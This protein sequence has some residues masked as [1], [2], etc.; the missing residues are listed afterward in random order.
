[1]DPLSEKLQKSFIDFL[2][3]DYKPTFSDVPFRLRNPICPEL[4]LPYD[5]EEVQERFRQGKVLDVVFE[6]QI[7]PETD[8]TPGT[9]PHRIPVGIDPDSGA[10]LY[11]N[12]YY[13]DELLPEA[14]EIVYIQVEHA[15]TNHRNV[16][17]S[18]PSGTPGNY[19]LE[20]NIPLIESP[21]KIRESLSD[22]S[23][24][25]SHEVSADAV[26]NE[27]VSEVVRR[28]GL[29]LQ[30]KPCSP[31]SPDYSEKVSRLGDRVQ[32]L[33][34]RIAVG[35][36]KV[37]GGVALVSTNLQKSW[38]KVAPKAVLI[39]LAG[40]VG[41]M[42][43]QSLVNRDPSH[44]V[45]AVTTTFQGVSHKLGAGEYGNTIS[46]HLRTSLPGHY[47]H[48]A[49][50]F[51]SGFREKI[52]A[53]MNRGMD[54]MSRFFQGAADSFQEMKSVPVAQ[55]QHAAWYDYM[56]RNV[57]GH[58][59]AHAETLH[60]AVFHGSHPVVHHHVREHYGETVAEKTP[61]RH[62]P[63]VHHLTIAEVDA[64]KKTDVDHSVT[65]HLAVDK[66]TGLPEES[67]KTYKYYDPQ[68]SP[69]TEPDLKMESDHAA[70]V[71]DI[72][73]NLHPA[74]I[75]ETIFRN[76]DGAPVMEKE[77]FRFGPEDGASSPAH[78]SQNTIEITR[79][80][81]VESAYSGNNGPN[82]SEMDTKE[83]T[84]PYEEED[85]SAGPR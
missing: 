39:G 58:P 36:S 26:M 53:A 64:L 79:K 81:Y 59:V 23:S 7:D 76:H 83:V 52:M 17:P 20:D 49:Q 69:R 3:R 80:A 28:M 11:R 27:I 55:Q 10:F 48:E 33:S 84:G 54:S 15:W 37:F 1:M 56:T 19:G 72:H 8:L 67:V 71:R 51:F 82:P 25:N 61:S 74:H 24:E 44:L 5:P 78:T 35:F 68:M 46:E 4:V 66:K 63:H 47:F 13:I 22:Y 41:L 2:S 18:G 32:E 30:E 62:L 65:T 45:H 29:M 34:M 38:S 57:A 85:F 42:I 75:H 14:R 40:S 60:S 77:E 16:N 21:K 9:A 70:M 50:G 12:Y 73:G 6:D 31:S 43:G